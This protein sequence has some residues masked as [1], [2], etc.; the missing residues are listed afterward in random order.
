MYSQSRIPLKVFVTFSSFLQ[1][2]FFDTQVYS[3]AIDPNGCSVSHLNKAM[4]VPRHDAG[5]SQG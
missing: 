2:N 4:E 5:S 1:I 3:D